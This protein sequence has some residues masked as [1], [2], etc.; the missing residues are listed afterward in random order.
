M[1]NE[2]DIF[3]YAIKVDLMENSAYTASRTASPDTNAAKC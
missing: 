3:H 2:T 1:T